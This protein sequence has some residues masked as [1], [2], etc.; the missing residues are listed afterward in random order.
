[1]RHR[2]EHLEETGRKGHHRG[3]VEGYKRLKT[4]GYHHEQVHEELNM[5]R[6]CFARIYA[7]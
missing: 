3:S 5:I 1:M 2:S 4:L 7:W 6:H